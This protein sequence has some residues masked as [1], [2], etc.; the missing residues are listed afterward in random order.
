MKRISIS[1][2]VLV[3]A[4]TMVAWRTISS[5]SMANAICQQTF[6]STKAIETIRYQMRKEE[7]IADEMHVQISDIKL[8][9]SPYQ[10]YMKQLSPKKGLEVLYKENDDKAFV[11]PNG[12]PWVTL[13]M[14]PE[15]STMLKNQHH[16]VKDAGFDLVISILEHLFKKYDSELD[17]MLSMAP[18]VTFDNQE[19]HRIIF[20]NNH[21]GYKKYQVKA[22]EDI[23]S[24]AK[25]NKLCSYLILEKNPQVDHY[26]DV[27]E[28]DE[29]LIPSDY[30]PK[31]EL[32]ID[33]VRLIPLSIK[34]Y[35]DEGLFENYQYTNVHLDA[36]LTPDDF[37][38]DNADYGF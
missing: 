13:K 17:Q 35:D 37:S 22:N 1:I 12:F 33:K 16:T 8:N 9:R 11:S 15:G 26:Y 3:L 18:D 32:L 4:S 28:G 29:I 34:V 5:G 30:S 31:M 36:D 20:T 21:F 10:V 14:D 2:F 24:I 27:D 19:C 6:A 7:R 38:H 25:K 23:L